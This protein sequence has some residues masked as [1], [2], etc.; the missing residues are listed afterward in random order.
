MKNGQYEPGE[1]EFLKWMR[2]YWGGIPLEWY[3]D[4]GEYMH[5]AQVAWEAWCRF[6]PKKDPR[7]TKIWNVTFAARYR[8]GS[9][10]EEIDHS[11]MSSLGPQMVE[12]ADYAV[13][14]AV[15]ETMQK[16]IDDLVKR[17]EAVQ[18]RDAD[19]YD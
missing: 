14:S 8:H 17:L 18:T 6:W 19:R 4:A 1:Y 3:E 10:I 11:L 13:M 5:G 7:D 16:D 9:L 15:I 2:D 12:Y